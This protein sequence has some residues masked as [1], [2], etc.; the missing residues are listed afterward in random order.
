MPLV[1][2]LLH[3]PQRGEVDLQFEIPSV[4]AARLK[5]GEVDIGLVPVIELERQPL[6]I[7]SQLGIA[8]TGAVRSILLISKVAASE[9]RTL[10]A[11]AS[12]RTSVVLAQILLAERFGARPCVM[13]ALPDVGGML[14]Q[15][16]ACLVIG[17]PALRVDI[18]TRGLHIYDLALEWNLFSGL[19]MVFAVWAARPGYASEEVTRTLNDSWA[20]GRDRI[21]EIAERECASREISADLAR[22]YLTRN[23]EFELRDNHWN[24][25]ARFRELARAGDLV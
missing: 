19:P 22:T 25:L 17:D 13:E 3:G 9:I 7:V 15:A 1:W 16:D 4:C 20:Y 5:A 18:K 24:G 12:S 11:D 10:A 6:E 14:G 21:G 23:I 2:G 8:C